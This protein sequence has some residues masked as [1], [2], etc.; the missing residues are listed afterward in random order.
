MKDLQATGLKVVASLLLFLSAVYSQPNPAVFAIQIE[1][2]PNAELENPL[3]PSPALETKLNN[4]KIHLA[5]PV[6]NT[7][8]SKLIAKASFQQLKFEYTNRGNLDY[9][10]NKLR[11]LALQ[12][13]FI[14]NLGTNWRLNIFAAP[15]LASDFENVGGNHINFNGGIL[16]S[17][18]TGESSGYAFGA[19]YT[20]DFG[21]P[22]ILP[23]LRYWNQSDRFRVDLFLPRHA[24]AMLLFGPKV[25]LGLIARVSGN[26]YRVGEDV[27]V[28]NNQSTKD[29][30]VKYSSLTAGPGFNLGLSNN[31]FFTLEGG[32]ALSRQ[33]EL[34]DSDDNSL[35]TLDLEKSLVLRGGLQL[36]K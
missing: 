20:N 35:T 14:T 28:A 8:V 36:R 26:H 10:P 6:V 27:T 5:Y 34:F 16:F 4:F 12:L 9:V 22:L 23:A 25:E 29:G 31:F 1:A 32:I 11:E 15:N 30:R 2:F 21:E 17:R 13:A 19:M 24:E 18:K 7:G 3:P 33:F